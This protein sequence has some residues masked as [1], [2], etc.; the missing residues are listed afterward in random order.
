MGGGSSVVAFKFEGFEG[1]KS[2]VR[3]GR[4]EHGCGRDGTGYV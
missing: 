2:V 1:S 3:L 4:D